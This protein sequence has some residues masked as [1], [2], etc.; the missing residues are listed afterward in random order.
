M[1][2]MTTRIMGT[3]MIMVII[4]TITAMGT[5]TTTARSPKSCA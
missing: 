3:T 5:I 1:R 2:I 4:T